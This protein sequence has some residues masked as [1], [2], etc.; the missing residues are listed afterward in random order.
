MTRETKFEQEQPPIVV[1][2]TQMG[3]VEGNTFCSSKKEWMNK[4]K[5][6]YLDW[7]QK[8]DLPKFIKDVDYEFVSI[9]MPD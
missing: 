9:G 6:E 3:R 8:S 4:N 2:I 5:K 1:K 7:L